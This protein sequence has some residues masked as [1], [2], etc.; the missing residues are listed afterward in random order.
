M[1]KADLRK[2][3][4][5]QSKSKHRTP[6]R[7]SGAELASESMQKGKTSDGHFQSGGICQV[8]DLQGCFLSALASWT[9]DSGGRRD[10]SRLRGLQTIGSGT[11][12]VVFVCRLSRHCEDDPEIAGYG[13]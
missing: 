3:Q 11:F 8:F 6:D 1:G 7:G 12:S 13:G 10:P 2:A 9:T 4:S 5:G